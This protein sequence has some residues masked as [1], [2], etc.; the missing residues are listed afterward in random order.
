MQLELQKSDTLYTNATVVFDLSPT[1]DIWGFPK[2][3]VLV[4]NNHWVFLVKMIILGCFGGIYHLRKHPYE[5]YCSST[6]A[7]TITLKIPA[8][9]TG[10]KFCLGFA[11]GIVDLH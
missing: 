1:F 10:P 7:S 4:P 6:V 9:Q 8:V 2:M 5:L 3:V 11:G